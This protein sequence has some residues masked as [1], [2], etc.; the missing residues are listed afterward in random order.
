MLPVWE[1][2]SYKDKQVSQKSYVYNK[3]SYAW[4]TDLHIKSAPNLYCWVPDSGMVTYALA[5][6]HRQVMMKSSRHISTWMKSYQTCQLPLYLLM[7]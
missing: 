7:A 1:V 3:I 4:E 6:D 5:Q 2:P